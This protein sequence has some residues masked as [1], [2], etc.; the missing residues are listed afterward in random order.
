MSPRALIPF[1]TVKSAPGTSICVKFPGWPGWLPACAARESK[2]QPSTNRIVLNLMLNFFILIFLLVVLAFFEFS[3]RESV[4]AVQWCTARNV[5]GCYE[6][7]L[8]PS[9]RSGEL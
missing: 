2:E 5:A 8:G 7:N 9:F 6:E 1:A 4:L 3:P